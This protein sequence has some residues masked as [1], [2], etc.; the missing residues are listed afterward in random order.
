MDL[1]ALTLQKIFSSLKEG[2]IIIGGEYKLASESKREIEVSKCPVV[3]YWNPAL[4]SFSG[5]SSAEMMGK[6]CAELPDIF[7]DERGNSICQK[8]CPFTN[9]TTMEDVISIDEVYL[10]HKDGYKRPISISIIPIYDQEGFQGCVEIVTDLMPATVMEQIS[11]YLEQLSMYDPITELPNKTFFMR[12]ARAKMAEFKRHQRNFG[13][14]F[15]G[16]DNYEDILNAFDR[17]NCDR[18][19]RAVAMRARNT[20]RPYDV[21]ARWKKQY[22][23][24]IIMDVN[25][26][27][28]ILVAERLRQAISKLTVQVGNKAMSAQVSIGCTLARENDDI[29]SLVERAKSTMNEAQNRGG[30]AVM[31]DDILAS[32]NES[33]DEIPWE[34]E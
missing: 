11:G 20:L 3:K 27:L 31:F 5:Y 15:I 32:I 29:N 4:E 34:L 21:I 22:F 2:I 10:N 1:D 17:E 16:I 26:E 19:L 9:P 24:A 13:V 12:E 18:L 7:I 33:V 23:S 28:I 6:S 8:Y 30:N 25:Q 14:V